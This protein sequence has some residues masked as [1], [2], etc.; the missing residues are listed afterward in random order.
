MNGPDSGRQPLVGLREARTCL[1][2]FG[3]RQVG[4]A[5]DP[6]TTDAISL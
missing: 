2:R 1:H 5:L 3:V 4:A 6:R